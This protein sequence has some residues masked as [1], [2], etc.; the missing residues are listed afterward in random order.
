MLG[1][2]VFYILMKRPPFDVDGF[3]KKLLKNKQQISTKVDVLLLFLTD[4]KLEILFCISER[5]NLTF[6]Y[7]RRCL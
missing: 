7:C 2:C 3:W 6:F 1:G 5:V 4:I